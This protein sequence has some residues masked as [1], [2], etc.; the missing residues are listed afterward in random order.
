MARHLLSLSPKSELLNKLLQG[1]DL[2]Y[3]DRHKIPN[4]KIS[5]R[6]LRGADAAKIY[7][8]GKDMLL[9]VFPPDEFD[10]DSREENQKN[11]C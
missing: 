2:N 4:E 5:R 3:P 7:L 10:S 11:E 8:K 6:V 1:E 9:S